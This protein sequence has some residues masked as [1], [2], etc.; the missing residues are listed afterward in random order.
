MENIDDYDITEP[1][2]MDM[3]LVRL[4]EINQENEDFMEVRFLCSLNLKICSLAKQL[5]YF[6]CL[7]LLLFHTVI[8]G[9]IR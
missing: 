2:A 3:L 1:S 6:L 9:E 4:E 7:N 5:C 8:A